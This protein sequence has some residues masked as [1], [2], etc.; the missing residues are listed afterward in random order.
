MDNKKDEKKIVDMNMTEVQV[1]EKKPVDGNKIIQDFNNGKK[2][3]IALRK[4]KY[5]VKDQ[6]GKV[7]QDTFDAINETQVKTFLTSQGYTLINIAEVKPSKGNIEIDLFNTN[8]IKNKDLSFFLTQLST[9]IKAG[10]PLLEAMRILQKQTKNKKHKRVFEKIIF[11]LN[12][13]MGFSE[14]LARQT[15]VFPKILINMVKTSELTGN[16]TEVLDDM[17]AYFTRQEK[18]AKE[19]RSAMTY[20]TVLIIFAIVVLTFMVLFIVPKFVGMYDQLGSELPWI[21]VFIMKLSDF[22]GKNIIYILSLFIVIVIVFYVMFKNVKTFK[23]YVQYLLMR[24]PVISK[25]IICNEVAM[26]TSTFSSL[27]KHD[28]FITDSMEILGKVSDNEIFKSL[29][30]KAVVN[31]S[32]GNGISVAFEN[33]WAFPDVAYQMLLTGEKTGKLGPMMENV[34]DYYSNEQ[35]NLVNTLK[36]LIEPVMIVVLAGIV[37]FVLLA[38]LLPMFDMYSGIM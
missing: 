1:A 20:P 36:S 11:G 2:E 15:G 38:V 27:I 10:I 6:K 14:A 28:V 29:I 4:Y 31:L 30:K 8:R 34:A 7:I 33:H 5:K 21:T 24:L 22:L 37:G 25:V 32:S 12:S 23:Y 18:N 35:S 19:I 17:S 13:G 26:F 16:L 3:T 9:Y